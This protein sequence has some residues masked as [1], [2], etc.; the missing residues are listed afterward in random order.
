MLQGQEAFDAALVH[1]ELERCTESPTIIVSEPGV[2]STGTGHAPFDRTP[3]CIR[4]RVPGPAVLGGGHA[5]QA[6]VPQHLREAG[7]APLEF[8]VDRDLRTDERRHSRA[9]SDLRPEP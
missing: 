7:G 9:F 5:L 1:D 6:R 8:L 3:E 2:E 4:V